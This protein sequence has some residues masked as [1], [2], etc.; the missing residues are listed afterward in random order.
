MSNAPRLQGGSE[1]ESVG[2][3]TRGMSS[4]THDGVEIFFAKKDKHMQVRLL[5][6][7]DNSLSPADAAYPTSV[8]PYRRDDGQGVDAETQTELFTAWFVMVRGYRFFGN[9]G[10]DF[11]SPLTM[12]RIPGIDPMKAADPI[13]DVRQLAYNSPDPSIKA[14]TDKGSGGDKYSSLIPLSSVYVLFNALVNDGEKWHPESEI[15]AATSAAFED[16]KEALAVRRHDGCANIPLDPVWGKYMLGDVTSL[17]HGAIANISKRQVGTVSPWCFD[18]TTN[19]QAATGYISHPMDPADAA[20]QAI[21]TSRKDLMDTEKVLKFLSYQ[22]IVELIVA[23]GKIPYN[24]IAEACGGRCNMPPAPKQNTAVSSPGAD[25]SGAPA[26]TPPGAAPSAPPESAPPGGQSA[27]P[28]AGG[29]MPPGAAPATA[30][31]A[32]APGA[33]ALATAPGASAPGV[34]PGGASAGP[35]AGTPSAPPSDAP[36]PP[37]TAAP[38]QEAPTAPTSTEEEQVWVSISGDVQKKPRSEVQALLDAG[39]TFKVMSADQSSGWVEATALG[40]TV[41]AATPAPPAAA[42]GEAP[43]PPP[44]AEG[45]P[46]P[47]EAAPD[48]GEAAPEQA[49]PPAA[50]TAPPPSGDGAAQPLTAEELAFVKETKVLVQN[51]ADQVDGDTLVRFTTLSKRAAQAGQE[52]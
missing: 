44:A 22:E 37:T 33:T 25:P 21:L 2:D 4:M 7:R 52:V 18:Y 48:P 42:P 3:Y 1:S 30:P 12:A 43:A 34:A 36:A 28:P 9:S 5:P 16:L 10:S 41:A 40:F 19:K 49:A 8:V 47:E 51:N 15:Y 17:T 38:T 6:A 20:T 39:Q 32:S 24:L 45:A 46:D 29:A 14:L 31:G 50:E 13:N 23:D 26:S 27:G 35:P 11:L